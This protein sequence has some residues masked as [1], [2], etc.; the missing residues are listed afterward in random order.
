MERTYV[1]TNITA[2]PRDKKIY[3]SSA[4]LFIARQVQALAADGSNEK[5]KDTASR[6]GRL[7]DFLVL[8]CVR[9][10]CTYTCIYFTNTAHMLYHSTLP[11]VSIV[12]HTV[13]LK[14]VKDQVNVIAISSMRGIHVRITSVRSMWRNIREMLRA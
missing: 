14:C 11:C 13:S 9:N 2:I 3:F 6:I 1:R 10:N 12:F 5:K 7:V 8:N 4:E